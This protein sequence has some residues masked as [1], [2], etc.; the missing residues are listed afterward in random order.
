MAVQASSVPRD[1]VPGGTG[2][3]GVLPGSAAPDHVH[4][5][6]NIS[7]SGLTDKRFAGG[8]SLFPGINGTAQV[9]MIGASTH[10]PTETYDGTDHTVITTDL[11]QY[12]VGEL[13]LSVSLTGV[14]AGTYAI[15]VYHGWFNPDIGGGGP[16]TWPN[17][18]ASTDSR[19]VVSPHAP[20]NDFSWTIP[21]PSFDPVD[22]ADITVSRM[23]YLVWLRSNVAYFSA[24]A[25]VRVISE[26]SI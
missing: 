3:A 16:A 4:G 9:P 14:G 6:G 23:A 1:V 26:G 25:Q 5:M 8:F 11:N 7:A 22:D 10:S 15:E 2:N 24:R 20:T 21:L 13:D 18:R 17:F 19:V 12:W